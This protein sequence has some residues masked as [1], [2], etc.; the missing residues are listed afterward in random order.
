MLESILNT[1][2][3]NDKSKDTAKAR[4]DLQALGIRRELWLGNKQNGKC[5]KPHANDFQVFRSL[6]KKSG[7]ETIIQL[8]LQ[9]MKKLIW[10]VLHNSP[11]ID[12][13]MD[14]FQ[15][16]RPDSDM[17]QEFPIWFETK[18]GKL[19]TANDPSCTPVLFALACGPSSTPISVNSGVVNGVKF[20]IHSR[21]VK[22]TTQN[23]G[24]CSP[25][26][27]KEKFCQEIMTE[28]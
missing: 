10:Y 26:R 24:I 3:M 13:Y 6:C 2:L 11:E 23:N 28:Y 1:L 12:A 14:E 5:S 4:Q 16:E 25:G 22:R 7:K 20:V 8:D 18:I 15:S 17:Q 21:D 27:R 19:Y 9:E